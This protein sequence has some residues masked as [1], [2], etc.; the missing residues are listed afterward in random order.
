MLRN[1]DI[2]E[3]KRRFKKDACTITRMC[4]CY[5]NSNKEKVM[6][7]D[8]NFLNLDDEEFYKYL[9]I[10]KKAISGTIGNNL[11]D[12]KFQ[13]EEQNNGG[14][15]QYFLGLRESGLRNQELLDI[16]YDSIIENY[17]YVGNYLI[18]VFH[19]AYDVITK[20]KDDL[21]LDESEEV[22]TYMICAIC[23]VNLSKPGLGYREAENRIGVRIQDWVVGVPDVGFMYPSFIERSTDVNVVTYY[24]KDAKE[25]HPDFIEEVLGCEAKRTATEE[26]N[27]FEDIVKTAIAPIIEKSDE[28][29]LELQEQLQ[30]E[31]EE[32]QETEEGLVIGE[33]EEFCLDKET[34]GKVLKN[35]DIP[36][37]AVMNIQERLEEEFSDKAPAVEHLYDE[38]VIEKKNKEQKELKLLE[39]IAELKSELAVAKNGKEEDATSLTNSIS[40]KTGVNTEDIDFRI[41][42]GKRYLI[43]AVQDET[44]L[45]NGVQ[46]AY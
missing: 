18:L 39:E 22:F 14:K 6:K 29:M 5:V 41:I 38:K 23:P 10:V 34:V 7:L 19:D 26:K 12:V 46:K 35:L 32:K 21:K 43:I 8:E 31:V 1:K 45:V 3:I 20:T 42:D 11:L 25:S 4:G 9:E 24:V 40:V 28:V 13:K 33:S 2:L 30:N 16:L 17:D 15:Q 27:T 44:V 37:A 36:D